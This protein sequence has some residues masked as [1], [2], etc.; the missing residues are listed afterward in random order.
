MTTDVNPHAYNTAWQFRADAWCRLEEASRRLS[1]AAARGND[2]TELIALVE[3]LLYQLRPF[4]RYWAFPGIQVFG[5]THRLFTTGAYEMFG[6]TV[7]NINRALVTESYRSGALASPLEGENERLTAG[8][9]AL[10]VFGRHR[11]TRPYFEVLVVATM[12]EAEERVLLNA[13]HNRRRADDAFVYEIVVVGSGD[14]A[15]IAAR[16]NASLQACAITRRFAHHS[17]RD[18]SALAHFVDAHVAE[19]DRSRRE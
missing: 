12:T 4:E 15:V 19:A 2:L 14:E 5:Q 6:R 11:A 9:S 7:T 1:T 17:R 18:L 10:E 8:G 13:I 16:L 3:G